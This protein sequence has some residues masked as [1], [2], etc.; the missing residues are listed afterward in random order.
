[1]LQHRLQRQKQ[2]AAR[3]VWKNSLPV[4]LARRYIELYNSRLFAG[5]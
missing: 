2:Q 1:M 4:T 5:T 3:S